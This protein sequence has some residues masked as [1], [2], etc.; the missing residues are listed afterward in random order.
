M[1]QSRTEPRRARTRRAVGCEPVISG[2]DRPRSARARADRLT[3]STS[4]RECSGR[5]VQ[6]VPHRAMPLRAAGPIRAAGHGTRDNPMDTEIAAAPGAAANREDFAELSRKVRAGGLMVRRRGYYV[7]KIGATVVALLV[8]VA[9]AHRP[10][11][12]LVEP[13]CGRRA[14]LRA[15]PAGVHRP[16]RRSPPDLYPPPGQRRHRPGRRQPLHRVQ[17]RMVAGQAQSPPRPHQPSGQG[18]GHG[19]RC[20]RSTRRSR[21]RSSGRSAGRYA[22]AQAVLLVPLLFL[23]ALN[24]HVASADGPGA[25]SGPG[26]AG[27]SRAAGRAR[28]PSSSWRR[29]W[30]S[31]RCGRWCSSP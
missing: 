6:I 5:R 16:R 10:R 25:P 12:Q 22:S 11:E 14:G 15:G 26:G 30:C 29:S 9:T 31:H 18:P 1:V 23:E 19:P 3:G 2:S 4:V 20:A 24:M 27:R 8:L 17:L 13:G 21:P 28:R 7:V